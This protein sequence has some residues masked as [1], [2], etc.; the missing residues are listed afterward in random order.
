MNTAFTQSKQLHESGRK[1]LATDG[2]LNGRLMRYIAVDNR[3]EFVDDGLP[4]RTD[5]SLTK[6]LF[7]EMLQGVIHQTIVTG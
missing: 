2:I 3:N 1:H 5:D 4:K 6:L 7:I